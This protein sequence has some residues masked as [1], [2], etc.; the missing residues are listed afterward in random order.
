VELFQTGEHSAAEFAN[1]FCV[2][3]STVYRAMERDKSAAPDSGQSSRRP[4]HCGTTPGGITIPGVVTASG[5]L[6]GPFPCHVH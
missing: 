2:G 6:A 4:H 3:R 1:L 5:S